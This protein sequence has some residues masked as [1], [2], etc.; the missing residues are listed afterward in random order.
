M[1]GNLSGQFVILND[2]QVPVHLLF[3]TVKFSAYDGLGLQLGQMVQGKH[4]REKELQEVSWD[5]GFEYRPWHGWLSVL[6]IVFVVR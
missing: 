1:A 4:K 6:N 2:Q 3:R 5:C